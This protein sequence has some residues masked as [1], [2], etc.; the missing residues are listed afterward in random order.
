MEDVLQKGTEQVGAGYLLFGS[1][2]ML[3]YTTGNGVDG[4]TYEPSLGEFIL[5]HQNITVPEDGNIFSI[6]E[7]YWFQYD[8]TVRDY[9]DDCKRQQMSGRYIGSLVADFH[10]NMLKGGIYMYP[11]TQKNPNGKLRLMYECNTLAYIIEQAGGT[12]TDGHK[13]ILEIEPTELHQRV[14]FFVGSKNMVDK[15]HGFIDKQIETVQ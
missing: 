11:P 12:A 8:Q 9:V 4:F 14:P 1:S 13:R 7:G 5:S 15:A 3:V 10:R 2:S 6:N